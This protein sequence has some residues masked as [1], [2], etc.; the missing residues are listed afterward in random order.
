MNARDYITDLFKTYGGMTQQQA[1]EMVEIQKATFP[2][3]WPVTL[4]VA[5][6]STSDLMTTPEKGGRMPGPMNEVKQVLDSKDHVCRTDS[7][8]GHR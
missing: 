7:C 8:L 3:A 6:Y 5:Q 4:D 2:T 1:G